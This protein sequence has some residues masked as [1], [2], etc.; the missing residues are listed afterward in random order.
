MVNGKSTVDGPGTKITVY[1]CVRATCVEPP[2]G[3]HGDHDAAST[4][5]ECAPVDH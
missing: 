5:G 4:M 3:V 1:R 2:D